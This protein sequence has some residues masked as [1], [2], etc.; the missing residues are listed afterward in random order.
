[1]RVLF[2]IRL[3]YHDNAGLAQTHTPLRPLTV[4]YDAVDEM[5]SLSLSFSRATPVTVLAS[6]LELMNSLS[7]GSFDERREIGGRGASGSTA[8]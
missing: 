3:G 4:G 1:M 8:C 2:L 7:N 6:S 5:D